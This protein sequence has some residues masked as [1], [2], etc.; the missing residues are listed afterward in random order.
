MELLP[1]YSI[2]GTIDVGADGDDEDAAD[3]DESDADV[4]APMFHCS[5]FNSFKTRVD[6]F[7]YLVIWSPF[8][9]G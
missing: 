6:Q 9:F 3:D 8:V 1:P 4:D 5:F 7:P 2:V